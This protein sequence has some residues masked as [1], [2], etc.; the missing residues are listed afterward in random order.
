MR[1]VG[2]GASLVQNAETPVAVKVTGL[3]VTLSPFTVA[4]MVFAPTFGPRSHP[5]TIATPPLDVSAVVGPEMLPPPDATANVT[6]TP[7]TRFWNASRT[8]TAGAMGTAVAI[9]AD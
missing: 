6:D 3:P 8:V 5:P 4:V 9:P 7:G 2:M 1:W